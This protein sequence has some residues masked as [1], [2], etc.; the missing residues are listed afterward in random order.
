[1]KRLMAAGLI[2]LGTA[3][4]A[5]ADDTTWKDITRQNRSEAALQEAGHACDLQAGPDENGKP[6][7][8]AYKKCMRGY[9]WI[10]TR[11]VRTSRRRESGVTVYDKDSPDP[12]VGWHTENGMRVCSHDCDNPEIPGSGAVCRNLGDGWRECVR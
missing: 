7:P 3:F 4:C 6:T 8:A 10:L 5:H 9:G 12:S 2:V 1:M 11:T